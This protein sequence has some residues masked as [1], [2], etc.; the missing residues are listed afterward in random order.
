MVDQRLVD[1]IKEGKN[2]G[3]TDD[4]LKS[5]LVA[6]K[7]PG[8]IVDEAFEVIE[9]KRTA[10]RTPNMKQATPKP[11]QIST[12]PKSTNHQLQDDLEK[13]ETK[14]EPVQSEKREYWDSTGYE[15]GR[16]YHITKMGHLFVRPRYFFDLL[17]KESGITAALITLLAVSFIAF[18]IHLAFGEILQNM[19]IEF[20][21]QNGSLG[22]IMYFITLTFTSII[23]VLL[24]IPISLLFGLGLDLLV[25]VF[26]GDAGFIQTYRIF[27]YSMI[28][29]ILFSFIPL[30]GP[31]F[32]LSTIILMQIGLHHIQGISKLE[33]MASIFLSGIA[34]AA[35][36]GIAIKLVVGF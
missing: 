2:R 25:K 9:G 5:T 6:S 22:A 16:L 33:A 24:T 12:Q 4:Q 34:F 8:T 1:W 19:Y 11:T 29:F 3:F 20:Y 7:Y 26:K 15:P 14:P 32:I 21:I 30:V 17:K 23:P 13:Q 31:F 35:I 10:T 27:V 36:F 28:P 18:G